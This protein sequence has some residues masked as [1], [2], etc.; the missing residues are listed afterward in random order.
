M[1]LSV[2]TSSLRLMSDL[3]R[4]RCRRPSGS[5]TYSMDVDSM[6]SLEASLPTPSPDGTAPAVFDIVKKSSWSSLG[7]EVSR[8]PKAVGLAASPMSPSSLSPASPSSPM[9]SLQRVVISPAS[10]DECEESCFMNTSAGFNSARDMS[11]EARSSSRLDDQDSDTQMTLCNVQRARHGRSGSNRL[12]AEVRHSSEHLASASG[13]TFAKHQNDAQNTRRLYPCDNSSA[14]S[15]SVSPP[16]SPPSTPS[17]TTPHNHMHHYHLQHH[18]QHHHPLQ[19]EAVMTTPKCNVPGTHFLHAPANGSHRAAQLS[20]KASNFSIAAILGG[21]CSSSSSSSKT[22]SAYFPLIRD[23]RCRDHR[24][25]S[26]TEEPPTP[27]ITPTPSSTSAAGDCEVDVEIDVGSDS[28]SV[29][30]GKEASRISEVKVSSDGESRD[31]V[32]KIK[33]RLETKDLWDKFHELG[34]EMI[35]TKTGRRMFPTVRVSFTDL[36]PSSRYCVLMDIVAVDSKRYRYAYHRSS[37]LVAGKADPPLPARLHLHPDSPFTGEHL[38]KQTVSFEKVKLTN[39]MLDKNGHIILNSMHKYQ[40]RVHLIRKQEHT[41]LPITSLDDHDV[42]T[43]VFP[44]TVFIAVTAYQNQLIPHMN[45]LLKIPHMN[46]LHKIPHMNMLLKIPHMNMLLKIPH[47]N[48]LLKIPHMN[49]LLKIPHMNMLL[50]IPHMNMLLKI[51]HMN[52]LLKI[53]HMNMLLKIP[54]MNKLLKIPHMNMLHKIPQ[55]STYEHV[56]QD[57]TYE[58]VTQD[59]TYEHVTQDSTYEHVTQD[60]TYENVTQD[61][62]YEQFTQD[63]TY[64]HVTQD[65]T[66]EHVTQDSTYEHVTQDSTYEH[67]T[68]DSTKFHI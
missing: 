19:T 43:F 65:S 13:Q 9:T 31:E 7:H 22:S 1:D 46:M 14:S 15:P 27:S 37:W 39:N 63:S 52:M 45:M 17:P 28:T 11:P 10:A 58:H 18:K 6:H 25:D 59:S 66:Y 62:T 47:M 35:I 20:P 67:V 64:E 60:S 32:T 23:M 48:M 29:T 44:E 57:S 54:H 41:K 34:T 55:N 12:D 42:T 24:D 21:S 38:M 68:Q 30:S 36:D 40:P 2:D 50:K 56:T 53:P 51:P 61:S 26:S 49:M 16:G 4:K 3:N 33:C 5:R 8:K